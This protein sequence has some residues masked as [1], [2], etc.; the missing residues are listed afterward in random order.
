MP[1]PVPAVPTNQASFS[2]DGERD[3]RVELTVFA[4]TVHVEQHE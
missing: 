2:A 1:F 3:A 4:P